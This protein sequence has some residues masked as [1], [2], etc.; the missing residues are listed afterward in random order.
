VLLGVVVVADDDVC[1]RLRAKEVSSLHATWP[2]REFPAAK[3]PSFSHRPHH[4]LTLPLALPHPHTLT[5]PLPRLKLQFVRTH[6]TT[7]ARN[8]KLESGQPPQS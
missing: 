4:A 2:N 1:R 6:S 5:H 7:P 8:L 3:K